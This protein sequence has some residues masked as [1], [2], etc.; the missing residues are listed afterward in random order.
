MKTITTRFVANL[1]QVSIRNESLDGI[2]YLV[3]P[4]VG[5]VEG[6]HTANA[7]PVFYANE[8]ITAYAPD[9]NSKPVVIGHPKDA[10]GQFTSACSPDV[11]R[12]DGVGM[13][14]N[15]RGEDGKL[16][17]EFW[18][19]KA[20][21][22]SREH[23]VYNSVVNNQKVEVSIGL[24]ADLDLTPGTWNGQEY[25]GRAV[26]WRPNHV[27]VLPDAK[28]ACPIEKGAGL[29]ANEQ[30]VS[31]GNEASLN[32]TVS[33][34]RSALRDKMDKPGYYWDGYVEDVYPG[35][36]VYNVGYSDM[37]KL[38][39]TIKD[40]EVK[41]SGNPVA[42]ERVVTYRAADGTLIGNASG[43]FLSN[44]EVLMKTKKEKV[45]FLIANSDGSYIED[46]RKG[47][48]EFS[49]KRLDDLVAG[50]KL[51]NEAKELE[52][53]KDKTPV[54]TP[55]PNVTVV[56]TTPAPVVPA[57]PEDY[58]KTLPPAIQAVINNALAVQNARK[59]ELIANITKSPANM[60]SKEWLDSQTDMAVLEGIAALATVPAAPMT[61]ANVGV[62]NYLGQHVAVPVLANQ[63]AVPAGLEPLP[64]RSYD[65]AA[66]K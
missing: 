42:V 64:T 45:D 29:L 33:L 58:I 5:I 19:N 22:Q 38:D 10:V 40:G 46:D 4:G 1:D 7:G 26:N 12:N 56:N 52:K 28:G 27:A 30:A 8:D 34:V 55:A 24:T 47:L 21:L 60:F 35:F 15:S 63:S 61:L 54:Q 17:M 23:R 49:E 3:V 2:D 13:I 25:T 14:F 66:A 6:V 37:Y 51:A 16:K 41:F 48:M 62:P 18:L 9:F 43:V 11:L 59:A 53:N 65:P 50:V 57:T 32:E 20:K 36:V 44:V 39:Y 31:I